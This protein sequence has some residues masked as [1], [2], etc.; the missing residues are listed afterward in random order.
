[1][2]ITISSWCPL[3]NEMKWNES[4]FRQPLCTYRLNWARRTSWGWWDDWDDTVLQTQDSKFEPWRSEAEHATSRSRRL[5]TILTFTRGWGRNIFC[6]FQTAETG[7]RTPD[8]GVKGSGANHCPRAPAR[9]PLQVSTTLNQCRF[10]AGTPSPA[11]ASTHAILGSAS[12][13]CQ[14]V[15]KVDAAAKPMSAKCWASVARAGQHSFYT[16]Q[17]ILLAGPTWL[18]CPCRPIHNT[19]TQCW[20]NVDPL[21]VT[22]QLCRYNPDPA[23]YHNACPPGGRNSIDL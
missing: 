5:P 4:G 23:L 16:E 17:G 12:W 10:D 2:F 14:C 21:Y 13:W 3:Q 7:N 9:C 22:A 20:L 8:S 19:P 11:P 6:F 18:Q 15:L 1:M